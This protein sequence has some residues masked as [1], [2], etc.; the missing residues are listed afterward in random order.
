MKDRWVQGF[1]AACAITLR[2]HGETTMVTDT[3]R[4]NYMTVT[5]MRKA[6]VDEYDI[7]ILRPVIKEAK[8]NN[9]LINKSR[10]GQRPTAALH[11]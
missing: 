11:N 7:E 3:F 10:P 2:N 4:C 1:M 9:K 6:G 5:Q 8:R